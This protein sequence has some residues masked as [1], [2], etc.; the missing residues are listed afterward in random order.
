MEKKENRLGDM[1]SIDDDTLN[2]VTGGVGFSSDI[3]GE[4]QRQVEK[5]IDKSIDSMVENLTKNL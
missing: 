4:I 2:K 3:A 1:I 5:A